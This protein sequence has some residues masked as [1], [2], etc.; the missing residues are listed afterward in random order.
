M[1]ILFSVKKN[2]GIKI[3]NYKMDATLENGGIIFSY[4]LVR[5]I[6][7]IKAAKLILILMGFPTEIIE[8]L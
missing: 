3:A 7:K 4:K 8:N 2:E 5:G 1:S 6:S